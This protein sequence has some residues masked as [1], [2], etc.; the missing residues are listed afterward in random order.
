M[1][2]HFF[3]LMSVESFK[4]ECPAKLQLIVYIKLFCESVLAIKENFK[5][6]QSLQNI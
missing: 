1:E 3:G 6:L 4:G 5:D 2:K